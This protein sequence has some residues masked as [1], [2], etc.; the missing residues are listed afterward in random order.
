MEDGALY[1]EPLIVFKV[2]EYRGVGT[3]KIV[4]PYRSSVQWFPERNVRKADCRTVTHGKLDSSHEGDSPDPGCHCGWYGWY[5]LEKA[6]SNAQVF[7]SCVPAN[8]EF[9]TLAAAWGDVILHAQGLRSEYMSI[10]AF[11][12]GAYPMRDRLKKIAGD[13]EVPFLRREDLL[14]LA[15]ESGVVIRPE[16]LR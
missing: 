10:L 16:D 6:Q 13:M 15:G 11:H 7:R 2:V 9:V 12:D 4:S 8:F 14:A 3:E 5:E 1:I